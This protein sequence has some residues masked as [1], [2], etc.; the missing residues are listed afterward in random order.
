[1][2]SYTEGVDARRFMRIMNDKGEDAL[3]EHITGLVRE[4]FP[5]KDIPDPLFFKAHPWDFGCTYWLPG[6]YDPEAMS[7]EA[8][9]PLKSMPGV[10]C[11]GES[12]SLRQAW[13]EGALESADLLLSTYFS[14]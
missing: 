3:G 14:T 5:Q 7:K 13:M 6:H 1:M 10:Y 8:L 12:F 9:H 2:I 4:M 11:C